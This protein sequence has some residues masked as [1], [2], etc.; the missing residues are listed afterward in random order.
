L[1]VLGNPSYRFKQ[2]G[3]EAGPLSQ[4]LF[5]ALAEAELPV[6]CVETR[7]MQAMLKA[8]INKTDRND[9]RGIAQM[10]RAECIARCMSRRYAAGNCVGGVAGLRAGSAASLCH[11]ADRADGQSN[12]IVWKHLS[13]LRKQ[14]A[15]RR[16]AVLRDVARHA[17]GH[18]NVHYQAMAERGIRGAQSPLAQDAGLCVHQ[19]ER[20]VIADR[21]DVAESGS[22]ASP[23]AGLSLVGYLATRCCVNHSVAGPAEASKSLT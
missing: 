14:R 1:K 15:Y 13:D 5:S 8:Q 7:H 20:G 9:A 11:G 17:A 6:I 18:D 12:P 10:M 21:T 3:L 23:R 22:A 2:I 4:W 16:N 19:R